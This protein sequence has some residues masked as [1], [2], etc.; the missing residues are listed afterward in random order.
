MQK[1]AADRCFLLQNYGNPIYA[2][3]LLRA[4]RVKDTLAGNLEGLL[5]APRGQK[6]GMLRAGSAQGCIHGKC[7]G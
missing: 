6:Q 4:S 5:E 7:G 2:V 1:L 3:V